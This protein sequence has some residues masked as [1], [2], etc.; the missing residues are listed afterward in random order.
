MHERHPD[1]LKQYGKIFQYVVL[2]KEPMIGHD[3]P[4]G[5][6]YAFGVHASTSDYVSGFEKQP[7]Y[8][9]L[10][11][12]DSNNRKG[13]NLPCLYSTFCLLLSDCSSVVI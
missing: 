6:N 1:F 7:Q 2:K 10:L 4:S 5:S 9:V 12:C 11:E 3:I 13:Y 8:H